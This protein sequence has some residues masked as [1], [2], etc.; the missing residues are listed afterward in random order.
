[1][2]RE[3]LAAGRQRIRDH[4]PGSLVLSL[5]TLFHADDTLDTLQNLEQGEWDF[6]ASGIT[7]HDKHSVAHPRF[8][9]HAGC[10]SP[11][12]RSTRT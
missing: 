9:K 12:G 6:G 10:L 4:G 2:Q 1:M 7:H 5:H 3:S 11:K 8:A